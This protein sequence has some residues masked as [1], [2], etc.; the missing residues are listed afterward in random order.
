MPAKRRFRKRREIEAKQA[1]LIEEAA[2]HREARLAAQEDE[3]ARPRHAR[4]PSQQARKKRMSRTEVA[5]ECETRLAS[6]ASTASVLVD[7]E[8]DE[9]DDVVYAPHYRLEQISCLY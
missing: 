3:E 5:I 6:L 4:L 8:D 9:D 1:A 7:D 2:R